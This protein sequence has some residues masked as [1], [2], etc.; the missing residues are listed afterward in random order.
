MFETYSEKRMNEIKQ[1]S[2]IHKLSQKLQ[3]DNVDLEN[4]YYDKIIEGN[5]I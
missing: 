2:S 5:E 1:L 4:T 3:K